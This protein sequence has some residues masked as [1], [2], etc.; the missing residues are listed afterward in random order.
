MDREAERFDAAA[1]CLPLR[2]KRLALQRTA[3]EKRLTEEFRLRAGQPM[4]LLCGGREYPLAPG[5]DALVRQ[6]DLETVCN[7]VTGFSRYAAAE[8]LR[9]GYLTAEGGFRVGLCGF[10]VVKGGE[11]SALRDFSS[12]TI[13]IARER[14][15]LAADIYREL[16][17]D[18]QPLSTLVIA[19]PGL[20]KTTFLRDL[21]RCFSLGSEGFAPKRVGLVDERGEIAAVWRG[22][23]QLDVGPHTDVLDACP[24]AEGMEILL[25][26]MDPEIIA[27]DEITA[28]EDLRAMAHAASSGVALLATIHAADTEE[29]LTKPLFRTLRR[30]GVFRR[31][32]TI[33]RRD[34]ER[35]Y[36]V[37]ELP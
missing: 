16:W 31:A 32:V 7:L 22:V 10:A 8:T 12:L 28:E 21:V 5:E 2:L 33:A 15:G 17:Q 20:G 14:P 29:L 24:K 35:C 26:A 30:M 25:R 11:V 27:V 34:S 6:E 36:H 18:D 37:E 1:N 23:P 3:E 13:R 4:T 19:P 9:R